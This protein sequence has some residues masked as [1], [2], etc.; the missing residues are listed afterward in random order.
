MKLFDKTCEF[1]PKISYKTWDEVK[2]KREIH[3][4]ENFYL[5]V[6][7][8]FTWYLECIS[9][10]VVYTEKEIKRVAMTRFYEKYENILQKGVQIIEKDVKIERNGKLCHVVGKVKLLVQEATKVPAV[11][12]QD[13]TKASLE[14]E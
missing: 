7:F 13:T 1:I 11:I 12:P 3:I 5:P 2:K 14:G 4:T 8:E 9:K 10:E 6:S